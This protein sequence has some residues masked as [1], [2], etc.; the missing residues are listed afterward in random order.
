[1]SYALT[2][3]ILLAARPAAAAGRSPQASPPPK[4]AEEVVATIGGE[5]VGESMLEERAQAQLFQVRTQEY[6]VKLK[7]LD[8]LIA[9]QLLKREA[10]ARG[11]PFDELIRQEVDGKAGPPAPDELQAAYDREKASRFKDAPEDEAKQQLARELGER[12]REQ[13]R[14]AFLK[15]LKE[16]AKVR[17]LLE[18]PRL[19]VDLSHAPTRGG[20]DAPVTIVEFSDFQCPYCIRVEPTLERLRAAYGDKLRIAFRDFPLPF[21]A[22]A[23]KAAE[24]ARC[25]GEQGKFWE[26][27]DRLFAADGQL[28]VVQLKGYAAELGLDADAFAACLDQGRQAA[29]WRADALAGQRYGVGATPAF[30]IN[31][32][33]VIGAQPYESFAAVIDDELERAAQGAPQPAAA[34]AKR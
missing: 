10:Q 19:S 26:M 6:Q 20:K 29:E 31:G 8:S 32:R 12:S 14:L 16:A 33:I 7:A 17:I 18:P 28:E 22:L 5:P 4:P 2:L 27:H 3:V 9:E 25:A 34:P 24:A 21:H 11:I 15:Q 30:F 13:R 23:P 1:M